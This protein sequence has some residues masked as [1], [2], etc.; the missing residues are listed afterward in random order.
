MALGGLKT[1]EVHLVELYVDTT[2]LTMESKHNLP[3]DSPRLSDS[4]LFIKLSSATL[5]RKMILDE[6]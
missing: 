1:L 2:L 3:S 4:S 6:F 5:K